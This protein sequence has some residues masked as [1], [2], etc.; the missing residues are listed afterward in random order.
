MRLDD[1]PAD[2]QPHSHAVLLGREERLEDLLG[3]FNTL[4]AIADLNMDGISRLA[5]AN[6]EDFAALNSVHGIHAIPDKIDKNLL[7]L[8]AIDGNERKMTLDR[9]VQANAAARGLLRHEALRFSQN[10][11]KCRSGPCPH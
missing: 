3:K 11:G 10:A 6:T 2:R 8:D 5:N 1:R 4:A 7:E 9:N